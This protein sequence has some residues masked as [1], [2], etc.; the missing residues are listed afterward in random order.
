MRR[1]QD[2]MFPSVGAA[3]GPCVCPAASYGGFHFLLRHRRASVLLGDN[4]SAAIFS[5]AASPS[6]ENAHMIPNPLPTHQHFFR[7]IALLGKLSA[8]SI[9]VHF[10]FYCRRGIIWGEMAIVITTIRCPQ[11]V[12]TH[13]K[14]ISFQAILQLIKKS[15]KRIPCKIS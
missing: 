11:R 7:G 13:G 8:H 9:I 3:V 1:I 14:P 4:T 10:Y 6:R 5:L 12:T 2:D 15:M